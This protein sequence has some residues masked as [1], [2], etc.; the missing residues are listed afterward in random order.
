MAVA[1]LGGVAGVILLL[2]FGRYL[3]GVAGEFFARVLGIVSTPFLMEASLCILGFLL[4]ITLNQWRQ[5]REGDELVYLDEVEDAPT[6]MPAQARWA[7]YQKPPLEP[8]D[9][10]AADLLEGAMAIGDHESA[11]EILAGMSDAERREPEVLKLRILL[12]EATGKT[13]LA[14]RLRELRGGD[15]PA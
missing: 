12:A 7:L 1:A 6:D 4:V 2:A 9:V 13:E 10:P 14:G 5:H 3:P 8:G 11:A 15:A